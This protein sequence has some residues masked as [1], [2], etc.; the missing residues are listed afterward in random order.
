MIPGQF[1]HMSRDFFCDLRIALTLPYSAEEFSLIQ[2]IR[3][4]SDSTAYKMAAAA[5]GAG[6]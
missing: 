2:T 6:T 3:G 5:C 1:G 4:I